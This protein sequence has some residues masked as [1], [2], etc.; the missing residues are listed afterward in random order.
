MVPYMQASEPAMVAL[1]DV[2]AEN[3]LDIAECRPEDD[4]YGVLTVSTMLT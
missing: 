3:V 4:N 2:P 1:S